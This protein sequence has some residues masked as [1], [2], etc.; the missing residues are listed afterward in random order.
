VSGILRKALRDLIQRKVRSALTLAGVLIGVAGVVAIVS[1]G[2]NLARAQAAA[3]ADPQSAIRLSDQ[4]RGNFQ[5]MPPTWTTYTTQDGLGTN[6]VATLA[7]GPDGRV[8]AGTYGGLSVWD[9]ER[10]MTYATAHGLGDDWVTAVAAAPDGTI[11]IGTYGGGL[12]RIAPKFKVQGQES[13]SETWESFT[14]ANSGLQSDWVAALAVAGNGAVWVGTYGGGVSRVTRTGD[15]L[16]WQTFTRANSGLAGDWI[17]TLAV[18]PDGTTWVGTHGHGLSRFDGG[19]WTTVRSNDGLASDFITALAADGKRLW[20]GTD[21]GLSLFDGQGWKTYTPKDGLPDRPVLALAPAGDGSLWVGTPKGA[22]HFDGQKWKTFTTA[23]G[24]AH[25][26]V[27]AIVLD[28]QGDVWFGTLRGVSKL[29]RPGTHPPSP[30]PV[31]FIHGWHGSVEEEDPQLRFLRRWL[32]R[33][34]FQVFYATGIRADQT[35]NQNA[36]R[37]AQ[38]IADVRARTGAP[39]VHLIGH[40][41]GGLNAR[42]YVESALYQDDVASVTTLGSPHAGVYLWRDFLVREI[43][44]GSAE[45]SAR[46]LLPEHMTLFNRTHTRPPDVPYYLLAGDITRQG[47]LEFL[48]FWPPSDGII[49]L[50]SAHAL[51]GP[52]VHRFTTS[53]V[54]GWAAGTVELGFSSYLWPDDTYRGYLRNPLRFG[55][56]LTEGE[57]PVSPQDRPVPAQ[58]TPYVF[59]ELTPGQVISHSVTVDPAQ[60]ARFILLWRAG[61]VGFR[62]MEPGGRVI[63]LQVAR[64]DEQMDYYDL[65]AEIFA[66][67]AVYAVRQP[68]PGRWTLVLDGADLERPT[69]YGAYVE[70]DSP[71]E[72]A[73]ETDAQSY[74]PGAGISVQATFSRQGEPIQGGRVEA[75]VAGLDAPPVALL[76]DGAHG[77]GLAGDGI[78]ANVVRAPWAGGYH[79]LVVTARALEAERAATTIV[80]VRPASARLTGAFADRPEDTDHDG[81]FDRL[82]VDV[83]VEVRQSGDFGVSVGLAGVTTTTL[84]V[85]L[86]AGQHTVH[87]PVSGRAIAYAARDGPYTV[88]VSLMDTSGAAVEVDAAPAAFRT[89][90]YRHDDFRRP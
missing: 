46:E 47:G 64:E 33:D 19:S 76:D 37:L 82:W 50:W 53:D 70:V 4:W 2:R 52:D 55:V 26:Y 39:K 23:D 21:E 31:V 87:V 78:Y 16:T 1:T 89:R 65:Q 48:D 17:T 20:V 68:T 67:L 54:H 34:G 27:S 8:W 11:W 83:G 86:A 56:S 58:R 24:L 62:L 90:P 49:T 45:P 14:R 3:Y 12:S 25:D 44:G 71:V 57:P 88:N 77:D 81:R 43:D 29:G 63:D 61:Q 36:R 80:V 41:M 75:R 30:Y 15:E 60:Q 28:P 10:W 7:L 51:D 69:D 59:G 74:P 84:P 73:V 32:E 79:P 42:A 35:L 85:K 22:A 6:A 9:G 40:S 66:N 72:L 5:L 13:W 38:F 18:A